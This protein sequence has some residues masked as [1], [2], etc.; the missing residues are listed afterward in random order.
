[1]HPDRESTRPRHA[2]F[3]GAEWLAD[4]HADVETDV[5]EESF[6][7]MSS[8]ARTIDLTYVSDYST[9][10]REFGDFEKQQARDASSSD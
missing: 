2:R 4:E 8:L 7:Q 10:S 5:V 9:L 1:M 3:R 6:V